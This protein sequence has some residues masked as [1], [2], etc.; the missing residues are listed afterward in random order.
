M[1]YITCWGGGGGG[2]EDQDKEDE[3][4]IEVEVHISRR[5]WRDTWGEAPPTDTTE[6]SFV[7]RDRARGGEDGVGTAREGVMAGKRGKREKANRGRD[8][9]RMRLDGTGYWRGLK[10]TG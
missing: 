9:E 10:G 6:S 5:H 3:E 4:E 8:G 7:W 1:V 2:G